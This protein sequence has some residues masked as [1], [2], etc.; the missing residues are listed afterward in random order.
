MKDN[1]KKIKITI[2][3][4]DEINYYELDNS[5]AITYK[6]MI[7]SLEETIVKLNEQ[8]EILEKKNE[9]ITK[10]CTIAINRKNKY[11]A[12]L[13]KLKEELNSEIGVYYCNKKALKTFRSYEKLIKDYINERMKEVEKS[14]E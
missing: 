4:E 2:H 3:D 12:M 7:S 13:N 8:I 14:Y 11:H 5:E 6:N 1:Y 9:N 10:I